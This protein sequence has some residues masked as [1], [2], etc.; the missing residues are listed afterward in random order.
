MRKPRAT[1]DLRFVFN[2]ELDADYVHFDGHEQA[3]FAAKAASLTRAN[4]WWLAEAALLS[5]WGTA[6]GVSRFESGRPAL[7]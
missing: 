5:Y 3:S 4:A 1:P 2:P 6:T 7:S